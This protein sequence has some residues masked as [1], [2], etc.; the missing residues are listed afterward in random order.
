MDFKLATPLMEAFEELNKSNEAANYE[1]S[2]KF[3]AA[4]KAG[5]ID[6]EAYSFRVA[7]D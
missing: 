6:A 4:A 1:A 5:Q 7:T 2:K 3:W